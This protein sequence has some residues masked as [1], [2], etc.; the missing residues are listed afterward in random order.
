MPGAR[1]GRALFGIDVER[2]EVVEG[3]HNPFVLLKRIGEAVMHLEYR[4]RIA[5]GRC[6]N[7]ACQTRCRIEDIDCDR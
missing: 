2:Q 6:W 7:S 5:A 4:C 3:R 1:W